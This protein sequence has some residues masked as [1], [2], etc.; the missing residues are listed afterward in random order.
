MSE[1]RE[2]G[3]VGEKTTSLFFLHVNF[4]ISVIDM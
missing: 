1:A 4:Y 2:A 3:K